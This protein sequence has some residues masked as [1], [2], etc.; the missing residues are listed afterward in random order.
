MG[1]EQ[2]QFLDHSTNISILNDDVLLRIFDYLDLD[3]KINL[4]RVCYRWRCLLDLQLG[5]LSSLRVGHFQQGGFKLTSGL[6]L[7]C[8]HKRRRD[9]RQR[10]ATISSKLV[11]SKQA[12]QET[13]CHSLQ[14]YD[15]LHRSL[16]LFRNQVTTLSLGKLNI[17]YRLMTS[18]VYNLP[19]LEHLEIMACASDT[20]KAR[21][22]R[23]PHMAADE[24]QSAAA[25]QQL[26]SIYATSRYNQ[27]QDEQENLKERLA[28]ANLIKNC[29]LIKENR[30]QNFWPKLRHL[31]VKDCS[32][33]NEFTISLMLA[34]SSR[35]LEHLLVETH[36]FVTG[37]FL[38]YC[39]P[40]LGILG[41]KNCP[42]IKPK[43]VQDLIKL[44]QVLGEPSQQD[45]S[46]A[47]CGQQQQ[48]VAGRS[49]Q[50]SQ[51]RFTP[52]PKSSF[53]SVQN[54]TQGIYCCL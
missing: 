37:E 25:S 48:Q 24:P 31:L 29:T 39:G 17:D 33:L 46:S 9:H 40:K 18:L 36:Q 43:F 42:Q 13:G 12:D 45:D 8:S 34:L 3:E 23:S 47:S 16:H 27:H 49:R 38:N 50:N 4:R 21:R 10:T 44:K 51:T 14:R 15:F 20:S 19:H 26:E 28:R 54:F 30:V 32:L 52:S 7:D 5:R 6:E 22:Q 53:S 1:P 35:S 41:I 2:H 11:L